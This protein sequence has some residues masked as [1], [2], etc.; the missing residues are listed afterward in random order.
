MW[1]NLSLKTDKVK[2][3]KEHILFEPLY[4][5][6]EIILTKEFSELLLF[7]KLA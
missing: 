3:K 2:D 7:M 6:N 1:V 4:W 5:S